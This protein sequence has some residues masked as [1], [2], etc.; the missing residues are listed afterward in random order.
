MPEIKSDNYSNAAELVA[1]FAAHGLT[2][3]RYLAVAAKIPRHHLLKR[4]PHNLIA[5][6]EAVVRRFEFDGLTTSTYLD[7]ACK[8]PPL[9]CMQPATVIGNI[10]VVVRHFECDGWTTRHYLEATSKQPQL[11]FQRPATIIRNIEA[12]IRHFDQ[13][14]VDQ[15][16]LPQRG[17]QAA[18]AFLPSARNDYR[19]HRGSR[20]TLHTRRLNNSGLPQSRLQATF[21]VLSTSGDH[22]PEC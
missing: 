1:H 13:G 5:N 8:Q 14:G 11:F 19:E 12:V 9:F 3:S 15:G 10:E 18:T 17:W 4:K 2:L 16:R 20:P 7:A 22:D 21:L 6:I